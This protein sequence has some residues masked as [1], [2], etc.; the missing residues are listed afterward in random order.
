[1]NPAVV[2]PDRSSKADFVPGPHGGGHV[3]LSIVV[4]TLSEAIPHPSDVAKIHEVDVPAEPPDGGGNVHAHLS[5]TALA[6]CDAVT[7]AQYD[8]YMPLEGLHY[9]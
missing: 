2:R 5:K 3:G 6:K 4:G 1:M 9:Y 7:L 8:P